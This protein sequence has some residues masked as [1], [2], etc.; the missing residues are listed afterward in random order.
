MTIT[1][2]I[3]TIIMIAMIDEKD[4]D[5]SMM[6]KGIIMTTVI[7]TMTDTKTMRLTMTIIVTITGF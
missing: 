4:N 1:M 3:A 7:V 2:I 5:Y 6:I